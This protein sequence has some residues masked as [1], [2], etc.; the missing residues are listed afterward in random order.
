[1]IVLTSTGLVAITALPGQ[2]EAPWCMVRANR[3]L[4][5]ASLL[6]G[7][8]VTDT[9]AS[10]QGWQFATVVPREMV[11]EGLARCVE[12]AA[13]PHMAS[14]V[15]VQDRQL[16]DLAQGVMAIAADLPW[17]PPTEDSP[18]GPASPADSPQPQAQP[19]TFDASP[20][21]PSQQQLTY[22]GPSPVTTTE[23]PFDA[24]IP[25]QPTLCQLQASEEAG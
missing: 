22:D 6:P 8:P 20:A 24:L 21:D 17:E 19:A 18:A 25:A 4:D 14:A 11:A 23:D 15:P 3:A 2:P 9:G 1:V 13:Y 12:S 16:A 10:E 7:A 5:L